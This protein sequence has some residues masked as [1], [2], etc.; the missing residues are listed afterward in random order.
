MY[1]EMCNGS[2]DPD[3]VGLG[4]CN[5]NISIRAKHM[6]D[7][8]QSSCLAPEYTMSYAVGNLHTHHSHRICLYGGIYL[9]K[10]CG[11]TSAKKL[12]KLQDPCEKPKA[13]GKYNLNAYKNGTKPRGFPKWP[14]SS[15]H[16][17]DT[18]IYNNMQ[19]KVYAMHRKYAHRYEYPQS[20]PAEENDNMSDIQA[21][22]TDN[23]SDMSSD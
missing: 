14:F 4:P 5:A 2:F 20:E 10:K 8:I 12:I 16:M 23:A 21:E 13:H 22:S 3:A 17:M 18:V 19:L 1:K 7:F 11:N 6:D 15:V 9:C